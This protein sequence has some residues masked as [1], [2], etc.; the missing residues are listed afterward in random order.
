MRLK[1]Y[2]LLK[3]WLFLLNNWLFFLKIGFKMDYFE[4]Q[5]PFLPYPAQNLVALDCKKRNG[6]GAQNHFGQSLFRPG[7][8]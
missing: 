3:N 8:F 2:F 5:C 4:F 7:Y 6:S 1:D